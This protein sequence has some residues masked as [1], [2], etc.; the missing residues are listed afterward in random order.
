MEKRMPLTRIFTLCLF[1]GLM[2]AGTAQAASLYKWTD[3]QGN[4]H[5]SQSPP[6]KG[7]A[8]RM[9]I[10]DDA[11]PPAAAGNEDKAA[12]DDQGVP[13]SAGVDD[14]EQEIRRKNCEAA[15]SNLVIYQTS[16]QYTQPD[17]KVVTM[18]AEMQQTKIDQAQ[19]Q[20]DAFCK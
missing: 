12:T 17:G 7:Q 14:R 9:H 4:V 20:V 3:E 18:S 1:T 11:P 6:E 13:A 2:L 16:N 19:K 8:D 15:R 5:Y 10:K